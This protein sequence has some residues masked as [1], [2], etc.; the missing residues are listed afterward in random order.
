MR[1]DRLNIFFVAQ[2]DR[3]FLEEANFVGKRKRREFSFRG[4]IITFIKLIT[5]WHSH[6]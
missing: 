4:K 5:I 2:D 6:L 3:F 1:V